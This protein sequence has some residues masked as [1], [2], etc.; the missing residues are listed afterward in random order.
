MDIQIS[1]IVLTYNQE[2]S[3]ARTLDSII[4]QEDTPRFEII[5]GD[6]C[7]TDATGT[8]CRE[9]ASKYPDLIRYYRREKNMGLNLNY[10]QCLADAKGKYIADCAGD[11]YWI[12]S[13]KLRVQYDLLESDPSLILVHTAWRSG[14]GDDKCFRL[15][16]D[17]VVWEKGKTVPYV[18]AHDKRYMVHLCTA[19]YRRK[20]ICDAIE[21]NPGIFI[22]KSFLCEDLQ[23][24]TAAAALGRIK[25]LPDVT[26]HYS[27]ADDSVSRATDFARK[28]KQILSNL[29]QT[30]LL[31]DNYGVRSEALLKYYSRTL[32]YVGAQV[33]HS[34][35]KDL[36]EK[37][38]GL[39]SRFD[40]VE[41]TRKQKVRDFLMSNKSIWWLARKIYH[42]DKSE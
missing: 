41:K 42:K 5:I 30:S 14:S 34:G 33:Y 11:D 32:E 1:V 27:V 10:Y 35:S 28:V 40:Y 13:R 19:M 7:S 20:P 26:L 18:L 4:M 25:Y 23:I 36:L 12:D 15:T 24:V 16:E 6:D 29:N 2:D 22:S 39:L 21:K 38:Y 17:T 8:V 9:Y 37:Y 31:A 3:I